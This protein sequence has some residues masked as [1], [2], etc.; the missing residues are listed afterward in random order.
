MRTDFEKQMHDI[1]EQHTETPSAECWSNL[2]NSLDKIPHQMPPATDASSV[3]MQVIKSTL[4]KIGIG[5][6][7]V[8]GITATVYFVAKEDDTSHEI[9]NQPMEETTQILQTEDVN[10][11]ILPADEMENSLPVEIENKEIEH[12]QN[13]KY[14]FH[15]KDEQSKLVIQA[16]DIK[17]PLREETPE[18]TKL[19]SQSQAQKQIEISQP[20]SQKVADVKPQEQ[21]VVE[22]QAQKE[23]FPQELAESDEDEIMQPRFNIPNIFTPNGDNVNDFFVIENLE[24]V[25]SGH[26]YIYSIMGKVL[27]EKVNYNNE[28]NGQNLPDGLY[29]YIYKFIHKEREFIRK[30]TVTIKRK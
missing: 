18:I 30:G 24:E 16:E 21:A 27:Y 8:G 12:S 15:K 14:I 22:E 19:L 11:M 6:A 28:W 3:F 13:E 20:K 4:G 9:V 10:T 25:T 7:V 5:V 29:L 1:F 17:E 2:S 26:L 23:I